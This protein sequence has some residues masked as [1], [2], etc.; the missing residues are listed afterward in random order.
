M[1]V[2]VVVVVTHSGLTGLPS[3]R[4]QLMNRW[5]PSFARITCGVGRATFK[6]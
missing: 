4:L 3:S 6:G 2:V 1:V 5:D